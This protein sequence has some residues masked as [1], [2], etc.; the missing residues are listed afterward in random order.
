MKNNNLTKKG[1]EALFF[2]VKFKFLLIFFLSCINSFASFDMN[3]NMQDAYISIINL[4]FDNAKGKIEIEKKLDNK[5]TLLY[6][7]YIDVF[8]VFVFDQKKYYR[9]L[10]LNKSIRL[11]VLEKIK[12]NSSPYFLYTKAEIHLQS[13]YCHIKFNNYTKA[14]FDIVTSYN[15]LLENK[16]MYPEFVLNNKSISLIQILLSNVPK[17]YSW[18]LD[19]FFSDFDIDSSILQIE[20]ILKN[21]SLSIFH[22]EILF[23]MTIFQSKFTNNEQQLT[24]YLDKIGD[25]YKTNLLLNYT[26]VLILKK[27]G[28][29]NLCIDVLNNRP[30]NNSIPFYYLDYLHALSYLYNLELSKAKH[31]FE[32]FVNNFRGRN[33]IKSAYFHLAG[34]EHL[35]NNE[36][37]MNVFLANL[38][39]YGNTFI[40][41][42]KIALNH[43]VNLSSYNK[44]LLRVQFLY[45]GAYYQRALDEL[46]KI[47]NEIIFFSNVNMI[48]E[49]WYRKARI[50]Q[51]LDNSSNEIVSL[52]K[53]S[54]ASKSNL[55]THFQP[56]SALQIALIYELEKDYDNSKVFFNKCLEYKSYDY[57][58]SIRKQAKEGLKRIANI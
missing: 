38:R 18:T 2:I 58:K 16:K 28:N 42:D 31:Y 37:K 3:K 14:V 49:Y 36:N 23:F 34:I 32:F 40:N 20:N 52:F 43:S 6:E 4:D 24:F 21:D 15:Y 26:T 8:K 10:N 5:I 46:N 7:N 53:K 19:L 13:A 11:D 27:L 45:D 56:M 29:N 1:S 17:E 22:T 12:E 9:Q 57:E 54:I 51:K 44:L 25:N 39:D 50:L 55:S 48:S 30:K 35:N 33:F 41:K 47:D